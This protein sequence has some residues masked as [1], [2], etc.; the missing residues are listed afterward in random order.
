MCY[1]W[2]N[3]AIYRHLTTNFIS[4]K[5]PS[6]L[7]VSTVDRDYKKSIYEKEQEFLGKIIK[8]RDAVKY[9]H[10]IYGVKFARKQGTDIN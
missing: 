6:K 3:Q 7:V 5:T 8:G 10:N 2:L 9:Q 1:K 4:E